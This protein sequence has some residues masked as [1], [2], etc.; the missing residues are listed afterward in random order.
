MASND[1]EEAVVKQFIVGAVAAGLTACTLIAFAPAAS[2]GCQY[3]GGLVE[4]MCDGPVRDDG[5]WQRC[6]TQH[7]QDVV[8][9][10]TC[11]L[12]GPGQNPLGL[13]YYN[14]PTHIDD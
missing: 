3:G 12:M 11:Q 6:V 13:A 10:L 5:T 1:A 8:G 4:K 9:R 14:P 2:A 7:S